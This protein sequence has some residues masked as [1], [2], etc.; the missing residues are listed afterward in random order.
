MFYGPESSRN[1]F[2]VISHESRSVVF[3]LLGIKMEV[4]IFPPFRVYVYTRRNVR[5]N[6]QYIVG[7]LKSLHATVFA[8]LESY[9]NDLAVAS[10]MFHISRT[11]SLYTPQGSF[12]R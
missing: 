12:Q 6:V 1:S 4:R 10:W 8:W 2:W 11:A 9:G 7:I 3:A 5:T